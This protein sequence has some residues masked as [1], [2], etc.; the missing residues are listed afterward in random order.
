MKFCITD[1]ALFSKRVDRH[2]TGACAAYAGDTLHSVIEEYSKRTEG[3][4]QMFKCNSKQ[5]YNLQFACVHI[6]TKSSEIVFSPK[7]VYPRSKD[8]AL[9]R[10]RFRLLVTMSSIFMDNKYTTRYLIGRHNY[11]KINWRKL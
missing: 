7:E 4:E 1:A 8:I 5:F 9:R 11:C 2:L 3:T 6:K 10:N